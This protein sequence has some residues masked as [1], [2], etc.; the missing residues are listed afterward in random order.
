MHHPIQMKPADSEN[1]NGESLSGCLSIYSRIGRTLY[2]ISHR[3]LYGMMTHILYGMPRLDPASL[4]FIHVGNF[5]VKSVQFPFF[6][7]KFSCQ[8][9]CRWTVNCT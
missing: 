9:T 8:L 5:I 7:Q 1:R 2:I 6:S 3:F 4:R